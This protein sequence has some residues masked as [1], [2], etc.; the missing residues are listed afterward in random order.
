MDWKPARNTAAYAMFIVPFFSHKAGSAVKEEQT[1]P[2]PE[3][4]YDEELLRKP[5]YE[6]GKHSHLIIIWPFDPVYTALVLLKLPTQCYGYFWYNVYI[7]SSYYVNITCIMQH[8]T[9]APYYYS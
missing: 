5:F 8:L 9:Y 1:P 3:Y 7:L 2:P 4:V 6:P